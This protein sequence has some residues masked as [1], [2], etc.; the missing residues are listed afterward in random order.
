MNINMDMIEK[1]YSFLSTRNLSGITPALKPIGTYTATSASND[2]YECNCT[3][4][5]ANCCF[6]CY[7]P[8]GNHCEC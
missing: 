6:D 5:D 1:V 7:D 3:D 2:C 8:C 4:P